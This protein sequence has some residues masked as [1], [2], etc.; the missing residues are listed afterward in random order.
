MVAFYEA[1][2]GIPEEDRRVEPAIPPIS[3]TSDGYMLAGGN[4]H[5]DV[6]ELEQNLKMLCL[7]FGVDTSEVSEL[8]RNTTDWRPGG[9]AYT[10]GVGNTYNF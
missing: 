7:H 6:E 5:G 10:V 9:N 2:A 3:I 8:M 1:L 4:F